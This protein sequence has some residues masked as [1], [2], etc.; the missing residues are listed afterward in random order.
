MNTSQKLAA[1]TDDEFYEHKKQMHL[2]WGES[3]KTAEN[4]ARMA[5][6]DRHSEQKETAETLMHDA[7]GRYL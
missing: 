4:F 2:R 7:E 5:V 1:M 3:V 6:R